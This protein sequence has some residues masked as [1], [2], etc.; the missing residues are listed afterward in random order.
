M[1]LKN[2]FKVAGRCEFVVW[3]WIAIA[4]VSDQMIYLIVEIQKQL[5]QQIT[6]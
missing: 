4:A 5:L 1:L 3:F 2:T 6:H